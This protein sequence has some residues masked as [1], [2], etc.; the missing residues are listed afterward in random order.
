MIQH[1]GVE[2]PAQASLAARGRFPSW[3]LFRAFLASSSAGRT[4][5]SGSG[6]R[7]FESCLANSGVVQFGRTFVF[8]AKRCRF[9]SCRP[10]NEKLLVRRCGKRIESPCSP[11]DNSK[12]ANP[13]DESARVGCTC[14][15][16]G[17]AAD[18]Y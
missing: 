2:P 4:L 18:S 8:D 15:L 10:Y 14:H 1:N 12:R 3:Q 6:G 7:R 11:G 13:T 17:Q 9:E 16:V 5:D